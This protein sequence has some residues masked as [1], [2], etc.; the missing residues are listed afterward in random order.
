MHARIGPNRVGPFGIAALCGSH[1]A[2][3]EEIGYSIQFEQI[4]LLAG[5]F[6]VV[7]SCSRGVGGRFLARRCRININAGV[8]YLLA[9][10]SA[11]VYGIILA[12]WATNSKYAFLGAMRAAAQMVAYEIAMGFAVVASSWPLAV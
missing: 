7:S 6:I 2:H 1:Q 12:G 8:L 9:L 4:S 10:S 11:G 5:T 3:C